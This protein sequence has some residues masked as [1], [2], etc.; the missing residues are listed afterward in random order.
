MYMFTIQKNNSFTPHGQSVP[1]G[2]ILGAYGR[3]DYYCLNLRRNKNGFMTVYIY[4][5]N[6]GR[7]FKSVRKD[8]LTAMIVREAKNR[9]ITK[10]EIEWP[11][12]RKSKQERKDFT[13]FIDECMH[14]NPNSA[15]F[16]KKACKSLKRA[17][18]MYEKRANRVNIVYAENV[19]SF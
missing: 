12:A 16:E 8:K 17:A 6:S 14:E 13:R 7:Y 10:L 15:K 3:I 19:Y 18:A 11:E 1:N 4:D 5:Q 9:G 2:A